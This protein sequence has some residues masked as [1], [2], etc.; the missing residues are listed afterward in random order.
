MASPR[1]WAV[2]DG[3]IGMAN[4][5]IGLAEALGFPFV[6]KRLAVRAPWRH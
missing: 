3:K 2:H 6:E 4:Q 1:V 5:V